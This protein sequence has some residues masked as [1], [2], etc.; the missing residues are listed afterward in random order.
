MGLDH[1]AECIVA[2]HMFIILKIA[3]CVV[4]T[5][6]CAVCAQRAAIRHLLHL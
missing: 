6:D 2:R 4:T 3:E 1:V 5:V